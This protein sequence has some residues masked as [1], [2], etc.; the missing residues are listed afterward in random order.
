[1]AKLEDYKSDYETVLSQSVA[2]STKTQY[3]R[4][5][6]TFVAFCESHSIQPLGNV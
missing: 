2:P 1:M 4:S 6:K 3:D 5:W